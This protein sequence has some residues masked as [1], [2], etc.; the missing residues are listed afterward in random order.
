MHMHMHVH[1]HMRVQWAWARARHVRGQELKLLLR[2]VPKS[3]IAIA[4]AASLA[5]AHTLFRERHALLPPASPLD[6]HTVESLLKHANQSDLMGLYS[7]GLF[8]P[9]RRHLWRVH[10]RLDSLPEGVFDK[11][12]NLRV[13]RSVRMQY[14]LRSTKSNQLF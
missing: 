6:R 4:P 3:R 1:M 2:A 12:Q 9:K 5:R 14:H 8:G 13:L 11:F 7:S 10:N